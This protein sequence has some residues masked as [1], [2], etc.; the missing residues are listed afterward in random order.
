MK[1]AS[2]KDA[3]ILLA[4]DNGAINRES[5]GVVGLL[6]RLQPFLGRYSDDFLTSV[7][8]WLVSLSDDDLETLLYGESS[9]MFDIEETGPH[10]VG[11]FLDQ[12]YEDVL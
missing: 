4:L 10:G 1:Y 7:N 3:T 12:I 11:E 2:I 6:N 5:D 8:S 9:E